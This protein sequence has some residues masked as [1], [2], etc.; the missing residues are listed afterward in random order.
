MSDTSITIAGPGGENLRAEVTSSTRITAH[1]ASISSVKV[2]DYVSVQ[3]RESGS[4]AIATA[5][6]DPAESGGDGL[7]SFEG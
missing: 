2:G 4:T 1:A 6:Q 7:P 5:I 3:A